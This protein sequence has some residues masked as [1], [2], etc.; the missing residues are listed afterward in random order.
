MKRKH[1]VAIITLLMLAPM[2]T[3]NCSRDDTALV[4][5]QLVNVPGGA[6]Q[7]SNSVFERVFRWFVPSAWAGATWSY[8]WSKLTVKITAP[9]LESIEFDI[10]TTDR[11]IF[12][13]LPA[14]SARRITVI[15][16]N[17][18][19][20][21]GNN[22]GGHVELNLNPGDEINAQIDM[23]PMTII[24]SVNPSATIEIWFAGVSPN[25]GGITHYNIYKSK[26]PDGPY[27]K[28]STTAYGQSIA[29]DDTGLVPG[30]PYFYKISTV[31]PSAEGE[32]SEYFPY[33]P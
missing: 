11:Q 1:L 27:D 12:V 7:S 32:L 26:N 3:M 5:I 16:Y 20:L 29:F 25:Y 8:G 24:W 30:I 17:S 9:D 13:E 33:M 23:L 22:W 31:T 2:F 14:G 4:R 18:T 28:V 10:P 19:S 21:Y 15:G 6:A